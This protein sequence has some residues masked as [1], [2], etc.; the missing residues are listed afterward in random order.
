MNQSTDIKAMKKDKK[1]IWI[2]L[3]NSPHIPFFNPIIQ[4]LKARDY[5]VIITVRDYAQAIGLA[6][7][8]EFDYK[9]VGKHLGKNKLMK[10]WGVLSRALQFIPFA[11][12]ERPDLALSHGSRSQFLFASLAGI[13]TAVATDYEHSAEFP[14]LVPTLGIVPEVMPEAFTKKYFKNVARFPGIK[15]DV[16]KQNLKQDPSLLDYLQVKEDTILV[17]VRPPASAAHYHT[18]LSDELFNR[19]MDKVF[20]NEYTKVVILPRTPDQKLEIVKIYEKYI[21]DNKAIIPDRILNGL[22]LVWFSDLVISGGGTMIRE[23]AALNVPA[24]SIFGGK[25]GAVDKYLE[26]SERLFLIRTEN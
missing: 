22:N 5:E 23:A 10:T 3:D 4:E 17:T 24:Y 8:F 14:L 15:E 1:K 12:K 21:V 25:I 13:K 19:T 2:D 9:P 20:A 16:Y 26:N 7:Y 11:L 6:E 18:A